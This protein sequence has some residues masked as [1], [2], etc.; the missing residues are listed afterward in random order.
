M[1]FQYEY[2]FG[3]YYSKFCLTIA[4]E[5]EKFPDWK[6]RGVFCDLSPGYYVS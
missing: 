5:K 2:T 1:L 3:N 4:I 6:G